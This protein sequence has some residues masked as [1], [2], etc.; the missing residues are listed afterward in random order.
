MITYKITN[1]KSGRYYIGSAH[2]YNHYLC[3]LRNHYQSPQ[4]GVFQREYH[5]DPLS[6]AFEVIH[7][8]DLDTGE[9]ERQLLIELW[10]DPLLYNVS[11]QVSGTAKKIK[12]PKE[13]VTDGPRWATKTKTKMSKSQEENWANNEG[14]RAIVSEV[15]TKT[16]LRKSPCPHCGLEMN[17]GNLAKH[18]RAKHQG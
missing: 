17:A 13:P 8:D 10:G 16:N 9:Y 4:K 5:E 3:R 7:V 2:S 18:I 12:L 11:R 15:V 14:R 6:F 1:T